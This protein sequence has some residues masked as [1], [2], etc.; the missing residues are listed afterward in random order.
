MEGEQ[1]RLERNVMPK[2]NLSR[3]TPKAKK[4][5]LVRS[6]LLT[7]AFITGSHAYGS[8]S[9]DSDIDLAIRVDPQ[10]AELL[11]SLSE[12][13]DEPIRF[14]RL[15]LILCETDDQYLAWAMGTSILRKNPPH[16][17]ISAKK[18]LD[19]LRVKLDIDDLAQSG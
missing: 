5:K 2:L 15:N 16:D 8:P 12:N 18:V 10:T 4:A 19:E 14:G 13:G 11:R 9:K 1:P 17:K 7:G 6:D 3:V